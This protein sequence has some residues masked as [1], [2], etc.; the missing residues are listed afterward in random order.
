MTANYQ[1]VF[2]I[3]AARSGTK[4]LRDVIASHP[5]VD[6]VPYDINFI[7][8]LGNETV[9]H[10]E[11]T[12]EDVTPTVARRIRSRLGSYHRGAPLLIEKTVS[13]C[14][15]VP[16]VDAIF[17]GAKYLFLF[18]DGYDV[19]ESAYRQWVAPPDWKYILGKA[20]S[21]PIV[22]APRY[23]LKYAASLARK[24]GPVVRRKG[25]WGPRYKEIDQDVAARD[26]IEVCAIQWS[27]STEKAYASLQVLDKSRAMKVNYE[28]FV[29]RPKPHLIEIA[30]FLGVD[31]EA[32]LKGDVLDR[33]S[34]N[35][36]GKG[37]SQLSPAQRA[38]VTQLIQCQ[39]DRLGYGSV[40]AL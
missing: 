27:R 17:P 11:L 38:I 35:N 1:P 2:V 30:G 20:S 4:L 3:G 14:L 34:T 31:P 22:D 19:V 18:R 25:T 28:D 26:L 10:D 24:V 8:R 36:I 5:A 13:N 33:I 12:P 32:Y 7:W 15:R 29:N 23:A 21:F 37:W 39:Q 6:S 40:I 9:P 16:F